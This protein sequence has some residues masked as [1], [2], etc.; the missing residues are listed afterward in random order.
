MSID[1]RNLTIGYPDR[2][3]DSGL[4]VRLAQGEVLALLGPNGGGKTIVAA[5]CLALRRAFD[6]RRA[7]ST[8]NAGSNSF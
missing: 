8:F 5:W 4:N 2:L 6:A 7:R 3:V 1:G